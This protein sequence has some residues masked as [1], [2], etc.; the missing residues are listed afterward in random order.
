MLKID[1]QKQEAQTCSNSNHNSSRYYTP[2]LTCSNNNV[3]SLLK[4]FNTKK[5]RSTRIFSKRAL[6]LFLYFDFHVF[7][8]FG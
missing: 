7:T 4:R 2:C 6:F 1:A 8:D 5:V 3:L